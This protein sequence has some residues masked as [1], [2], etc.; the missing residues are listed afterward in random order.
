[1]KKTDKKWRMKLY[2]MRTR[3]NTILKGLLNEVD[4]PYHRDLAIE[5][6]SKADRSI[7]SAANYMRHSEDS[8]RTKRSK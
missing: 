6:I 1:M 4:E 5:A 8:W 3:L 7:I 2:E